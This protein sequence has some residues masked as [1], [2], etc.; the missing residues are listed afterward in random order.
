MYQFAFQCILMY[1]SI[2]K[3]SLL[4]NFRSRIRLRKLIS[5]N[6]STANFS[7]TKNL[8]HY[9]ANYSVR[10]S[11][12]SHLRLFRLG[13]DKT[14]RGKCNRWDLLISCAS[15][16]EYFLRPVTVHNIV[17]IA[18]NSSKNSS[19]TVTLS[20]QS[21]RI[22]TCSSLPLLTCMCRTKASYNNNIQMLMW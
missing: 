12:S 14:K 16:A 1:P 11:T 4:K 7:T 20:I 13:V 22:Y 15:S 19:M 9:S 18:E 10:H 17:L 3:F 8:K 2:G 6:I 5:Q 21:F